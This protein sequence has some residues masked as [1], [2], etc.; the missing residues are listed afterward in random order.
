MFNAFCAA[1]KQSLSTPEIKF[2]IRSFVHSG[3][4]CQGSAGLTPFRAFNAADIVKTMTTSLTPSIAA[5]QITDI[6][7]D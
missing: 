1:L 7:A 6:E 2:G 5:K 4:E 3:R